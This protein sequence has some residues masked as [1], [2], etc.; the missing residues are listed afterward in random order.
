MPSWSHALA[1]AAADMTG[2][3]VDAVHTDPVWRDRADF[4]V[5]AALPQT[6]RAEQLW[7]R[8]IDDRLF[9]VCCIPFFL[10]DVALGDIVETDARHELLHVV[11][12][13]GRFVFRAW[14]GGAGH[15][16]EDVVNE[17]TELGALFEWSATDLLAIDAADGWHSRVLAEYLAGHERMGHFLY[18]TG[19]T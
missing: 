4:I 18:E 3:R 19:R 15:P 2:E 11:E 17:L 6:D 7:A 12:P 9:E 10:Y 1:T 5:G 8:Q 13:S 16:R 14:F